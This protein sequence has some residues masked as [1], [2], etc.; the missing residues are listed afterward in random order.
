MKRVVFVGV[1]RRLGESLYRSKHRQVLGATKRIRGSVGSGT[2]GPPDAV[3][4]AFGVVRQLV[5]DD[6][7][8]PVDIDTTRHDIRCD[9]DPDLA[10]IKPC[11]RPLP[12]IL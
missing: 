8:D 9:Q 5:V 3:H 4:V 11:E 12:G 2:G 7:R 10:V 6:M 1:Q